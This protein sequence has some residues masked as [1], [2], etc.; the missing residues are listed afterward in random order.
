MGR[1]DHHRRL[2][3]ARHAHA[4]AGEA[5][6]P[7]QL[8]EQGEI[9]RRLDIRRAECTSGRRPAGPPRA[10]ARAG[11]GRSATGAAALLRLVAD[12]DLEEA[13]GPP[14]RLRHRLGQRRDQRRPVDRMDRRRT[15]RRRPRPCWTEA[16]RSGGAEGR[17][18]RARSAGHLACASCTRFSPKSRWPGGDQ[19][20]DRLG[21]A[22][23]WR[24]RSG[25]PRR[26][27]A[28]ASLAARGDPV[29]DLLEPF[30]VM[31]RSWRLL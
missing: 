6:T 28:P 10:P 29:A 20:L 1:A 19:R 9:G 13:V 18:A 14:A 2:E 16:G 24:R 22:G 21:A 11:P 8:G 26:P 12:I 7:R 30:A 3:I 25:S 5:M 17:D 31:R 27:A 4:E 15:G 23:S